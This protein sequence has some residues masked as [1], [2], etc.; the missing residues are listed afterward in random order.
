MKLVEQQEYIA[1]YKSVG[2]K[3]Y[4]WHELKP[5]NLDIKNLLKGVEVIGVYNNKLQNENNILKRELD[6]LKQELTIT[7]NNLN[8][9]L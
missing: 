8:K 4:D 2:N 3:I 9:L 5:D 1:W 6:E 7:L